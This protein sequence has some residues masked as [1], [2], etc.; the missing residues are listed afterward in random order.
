M[1]MKNMKDHEEKHI[2]S[3]AGAMEIIGFG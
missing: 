3:Q 2:G 1:T